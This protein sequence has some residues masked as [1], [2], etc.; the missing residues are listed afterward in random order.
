ML[1]EMEGKEGDGGGGT[2]EGGEAKL[3]GKVGEAGKYYKLC[4]S[5]ALPSCLELWP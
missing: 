3:E 1:C 4:N 2:G 5:D